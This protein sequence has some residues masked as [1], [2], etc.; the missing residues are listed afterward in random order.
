M[1]RSIIIAA[2]AAL[3]STP[4]SAQDFAEPIAS[5]SRIKTLVY[6]ENEVYRIVT[7]YGFQ[8]NIEFARSEEVETISLGDQVGWQVVPSGR[9]L[10]IKALEENGRTNMTVITNRRVYQ[11]DLKARA[12]PNARDE[13]L[14]YVIRFYY[15][16]TGRAGA[17][18]AMAAPAPEPAPAATASVP[19][20]AAAP[21]PAAPAPAAPAS[22]SFQEPPPMTQAAYNFNYTLA[23]SSENAPLKVFDDGRSTYF[24]FPGGAAPQITHVD[25]TGA[26]TPVQAR[27]VGDYVVVDT[28]GWQF[29]LRSGGSLICV[30]NEQWQAGVR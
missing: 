7:N 22:L 13:D 3:L 16:E 30:F 12:N 28:V 10:F 6:N 8:S 15:P 25:R 26:E 18:G 4:V 2:V 21:L 19:L 5:D 23:G 9:H 17:T 20:P 24:Q 27:A 29:A 1:K 14:A 11:F